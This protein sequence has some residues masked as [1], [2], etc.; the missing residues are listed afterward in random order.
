MQHTSIVGTIPT[1]MITTKIASK[2][3]TDLDTSA[4]TNW[5]VNDVIRHKMTGHPFLVVHIYKYVCT[6]VVD[7]KDDRKLRPTLTLLPSDYD[8]Y[9]PDWQMEEL[10][11]G[12]LTYKPVEI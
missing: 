2:K 9:A 3:I 12:K 1:T 4:R 11:D 5:Q 8:E 6:I 7:L 10:V